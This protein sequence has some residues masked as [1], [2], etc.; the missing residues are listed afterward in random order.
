M[1]ARTLYLLDASN[2]IFRAFHATRE[3]GLST[4][5]GLPTNAA[6]VFTNMVRKLLREHSP[7]HFACVFDS[8]T[9]KAGRKALYADYKANRAATPPD[10][11]AQMPFM[12]PLASALGL[13]IIE[14]DGYEADDVIATL[15]RGYAAGGWDVVMV[16]SDKDL[17]QLLGHATETGGRVRLFDANKDF[18]KGKWIGLDECEEKFGVG[19]DRVVEVQGLIG[20]D[21]DNIPGVDG[22]GPKTAAKLIVEHGTLEGV[23]ASLE[24][25]KG[26]L[27]ERLEEGRDNAFLS[28]ELARLRADLPLSTHNEDYALSPPD[29]AALVELFSTLEF[30][31]LLREVQ[32]VAAPRQEV[33][34]AVVRDEAAL[35]ALALALA[36]APTFAVFGLWDHPV[37]ARSRLVGLAF[38]TTTA[39]WYVPLRHRLLDAGDQVSVA[40]ALERL[41]PA[42]SAK[43]RV[44]HAWKELAFVL[45]REGLRVPGPRLDT[46]LASYLSN[47][48]KYAHTL[49]NLALDHLRENLPPLPP[50]VERGRQGWDETPV[51]HA[52]AAAFARVEAIARLE[53]PLTTALAE[54]QGA[55]LLA[56]LELPLSEILLDME[57]AGVRVEPEILRGLSGRFGEMLA[58]AERRVWGLAGTEFN[59]GSP[60]QLA[61]VLFERLGL[62]VLKKTKTGPS[63]DA[64]VLEQLADESPV[65]SG[66][67]EYRE[68]SKLKGTY[69]DVLPT[70]IDRETGRIHTSFR[71]AVAATGRLSSF[72]PNLQNIPIRTE[73]GRRIR[74]AFVAREG[75]V[76]VSADYSQVELRIL[77]HLCRDPG[78]LGAFADRVDVHRR[79]A[80]EIFGVP[81]PEV[82]RE[83]RSAA[84]A[85]NFGLM[86]G[87]GA[88]R[89]AR[90]LQ[91]SRKKAQ[92][93]IDR[94]FERYSAVKAF[95]DGTIER[96]RELGYVETVLGRRRYVPDLRARDFARRSGAERVAINTP[97]QGSAA[98]IIKLAMLEVARVLRGEGF[99][100][101]MV[102]QVHDELVFDAP[103]GEAE[104][105][106]ERVR[107]SMSGV[108]SLA[109]PLDVEVGW[110]RT[111]NDAHA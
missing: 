59:L 81:E 65:V 51:E 109:V 108:V 89:L 3:S 57:L 86:Y 76:L 95:M 78:L 92:E 10:L 23:Y 1:A 111:W 83:H 41:T 28:R 67:L 55:G 31:D 19:P 39:A 2:F 8:A 5:T 66:I 17:Y 12:R 7:S 73:E 99:S 27:R 75:N 25:I 102:L 34:R 48:T 52:A 15:A 54:A 103:E 21:S 29:N 35:G 80:S 22:V 9:G 49:E 11:A 104:R 47:A 93:Y 45:A 36:S 87:M 101:R 64:S 26:K 58:A 105:L 4:S 63:T 94:Y 100:A 6:L 60:K 79:T 37:Y 70:L 82:T 53:A 46:E 43:E 18:N 32:V 77:A 68:L 40:V 62:P 42:L 69:T 84:K 74:D 61:E 85:I 110:G 33:T 90:D 50:E 20:D 56:E 106:A 24:T 14:H 44:A 88:F 38:A 16:S 96:G 13:S 72:D 98:D 91:I 97:V 107:A 30:K 71:Q